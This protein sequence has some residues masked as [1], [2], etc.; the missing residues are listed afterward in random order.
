MAGPF[1][2]SKVIL[3]YLILNISQAQ[4]PL[5]DG[6]G[7]FEES[8]ALLVGPIGGQLGSPLVA[9]QCDSGRALVSGPDG[10]QRG[11]PEG[12]SPIRASPLH[13]GGDDY[14]SDDFFRLPVGG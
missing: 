12:R 3:E 13:E 6:E 10:G 11:S 4:L 5:H 7:A 1:D 8:S 14:V 2:K 9:C